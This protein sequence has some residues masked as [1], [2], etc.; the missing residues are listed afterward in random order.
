LSGAL[1]EHG[2]HG[3]GVE[4]NRPFRFEVRY[5]PGLSFSAK[6]SHGNP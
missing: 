3:V 4:Q 6:P 5:T 1:D 2:F